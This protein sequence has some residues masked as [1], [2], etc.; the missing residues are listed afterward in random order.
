MQSWLF[1]LLFIDLISVIH[2]GNC[3]SLMKHSLII[4][5]FSLQ[6]LSPSHQIHYSY[7]PQIHLGLMIE[8]WASLGSDLSTFQ[9][10]IQYS[11][12]MAELCFFDDFH[13]PSLRPMKL[14]NTAL[15]INWDLLLHYF[16]LECL[17]IDTINKLIS[18]KHHQSLGQHLYWNISSVLTH[19]DG[20]T[21][22]A[23]VEKYSYW[24]S[25][26]F[27]KTS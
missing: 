5:F 24:K 16:R 12:F 2:D 13:N 19:C 4:I 9:Y 1:T 17:C 14:L 6:I 25:M 21:T 7:Y 15:L 27:L 22:P 10:S 26:H 3:R 11:I 8:V 23:N 20:L 18:C